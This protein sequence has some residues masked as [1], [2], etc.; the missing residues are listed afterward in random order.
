[1]ITPPK[2][3]DEEQDAVI[4]TLGNIILRGDNVILISPP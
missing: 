2:E 4:E 3:E 1:M